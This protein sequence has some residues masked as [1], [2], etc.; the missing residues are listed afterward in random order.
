MCAFCAYRWANNFLFN[1]FPGFQRWRLGK[2]MPIRRR[3]VE[4]HRRRVP[5]ELM[6]FETRESPTS[7]SVYGSALLGNADSLLPAPDEQSPSV[8]QP[9]RPDQLQV[10]MPLDVGPDGPAGPSD[11]ESRPAPGTYT[12]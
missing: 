12:N 7:F 4:I 2:R 1:H 6:L 3:P 11:A 10:V 5:L 9:I 8:V